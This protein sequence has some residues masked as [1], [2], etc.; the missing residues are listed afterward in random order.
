MSRNTGQYV[1]EKFVDI[2]EVPI[3][4]KKINLTDLLYL[5]DLNL[6]HDGFFVITY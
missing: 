2:L 5:D 1:A 6:G 3:L 4:S